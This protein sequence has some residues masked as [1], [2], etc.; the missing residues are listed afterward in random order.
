VSPQRLLRQAAASAD[1]ADASRDPIAN[2]VLANVDPLAPVT[3]RPIL[4]VH[5]RLLS[6]SAQRQHAGLFRTEQNWIGGNDFNPIGAAF[7]PP[8][9]EH[10]WI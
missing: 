7:V 9:H 10:V 2:E 8:P 4:E 6:A 5:R 3:A 1:G